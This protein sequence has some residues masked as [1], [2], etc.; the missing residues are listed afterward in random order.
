MGAP[1]IVVGW[2]VDD[3]GDAVVRLS[4]L[5]KG[6]QHTFDLTPETARALASAVQTH[7]QTVEE[8]NRL[9]GVF[10]EHLRAQ[11]QVQ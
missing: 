10:I 2:A 6:Y 7:A 5:S 9:C 3:E 1:E 11:E 8:K 4:F